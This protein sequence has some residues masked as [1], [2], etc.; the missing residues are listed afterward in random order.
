MCIRDSLKAEPMQIIKALAD[1]GLS[2][3]RVPWSGDALI[4]DHADE[5]AVAALPMFESGEI[6]MPVS[7]TH[8]CRRCRFRRGQ[9]TRRNA[10]C[11]A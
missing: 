11:T 7:Y 10:R 5:G 6:Y 2:A 3:Q 8:L 1:A 4:L 9:N